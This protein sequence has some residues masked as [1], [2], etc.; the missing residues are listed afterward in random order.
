MR[1]I[2]HASERACEEIGCGRSTRHASESWHPIDLS[3]GIQ[4]IDDAG[5]STITH[6]ER[7]RFSG[8]QLSL[9]SLA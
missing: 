3:A 8:C 1:R 9:L 2:R 5:Y 6:H 4:A 7:G